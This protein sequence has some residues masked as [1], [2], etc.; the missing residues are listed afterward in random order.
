M[1]TAG[2]R[3]GL[4]QRHPAI[5]GPGVFASQNPQ[6]L[7]TAGIHAGHPCG[8]SPWKQPESYVKTPKFNR[9]L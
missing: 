7:E 3:A 9:F 8:F 1:E 5:F 4:K 6:E 2:I